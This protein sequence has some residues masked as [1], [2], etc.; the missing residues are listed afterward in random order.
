MRSARRSCGRRAG[1]PTAPPCSRRTGAAA[2]PATVLQAA[3]SASSGG[4]APMPV[5]SH[6]LTARLPPLVPP[7]GLTIRQSSATKSRV[8][9]PTRL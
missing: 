2:A 9:L 1:A 8:Q 6:N 3:A 7:A 4:T 5:S